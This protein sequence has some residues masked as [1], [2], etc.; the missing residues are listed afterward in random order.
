MPIAQ[1]ICKGCHLLNLSSVNVQCLQY[2]QRC[3]RCNVQCCAQCNCAASSTLQNMKFCMLCKL[4]V[5]SIVRYMEGC[6]QIGSFFIK[7][8]YSF[9]SVG[10]N[11]SFYCITSLEFKGDG[12]FLKYSLLVLQIEGWGKLTYAVCIVQPTMGTIYARRV[13]GISYVTRTVMQLLLA[14]VENAIWA[15][16]KILTLLGTI[17][18]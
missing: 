14:N 11:E 16:I 12:V 2:R 18:E 1:N 5:P 3:S 6:H 15:G 7:H 10:N 13:N 9:C 17:V 4:V 8:L